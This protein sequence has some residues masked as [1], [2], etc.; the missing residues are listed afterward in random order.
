M[1]ERGLE[2]TAVGESRNGNNEEVEEKTEHG[3]TDSDAG[4]NLVDEE[5]V[6]GDGIAN[7]ESGLE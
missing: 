2:W 6:F 5:D 1:R 4:G 7:E 3:E